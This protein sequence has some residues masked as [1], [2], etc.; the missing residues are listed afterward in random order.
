MNE[1]PDV[2][3]TYVRGDVIPVIK[4]HP[5]CTFLTSNT[6]VIK[7]L[8]TESVPPFALTIVDTFIYV[9]PVVKE[10]FINSL[11]EKGIF[12]G[13]TNILSAGLIP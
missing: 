12:V 2:P 3:I 9:A 11:R 10:E 4:Q 13:F 7:R 6:D 5:N 8:Q 1:I